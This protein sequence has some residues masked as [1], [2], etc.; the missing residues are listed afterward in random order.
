VIAPFVLNRLPVFLK[1]LPVS[2]EKTGIECQA[3]FESGGAPHDR[4]DAQIRELTHDLVFAGYG[5]HGQLKITERQR[6][7]ASTS[8]CRAR[9]NSS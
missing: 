7:K 3:V 9:A 4:V 8:R 5:P 6:K 2:A 1:N